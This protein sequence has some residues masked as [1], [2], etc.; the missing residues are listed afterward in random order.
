M[1]KKLIS[2]VAGAALVL[3][4]GA[5]VR[6]FFFPPSPPFITDQWPFCV[7]NLRQIQSAKEQWALESKQ[8]AN[9]LPTW[10]DIR[11]YLTTKATSGAALTC[12]DGGT[13]T[14]GGFGELPR[15]SLGPFVGRRSHTLDGH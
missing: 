14:I 5:T 8:P 1:P 2:A 12:P 7:S 11:P 13:Y 15:C 9:V 3:I 10:D 4:V 6:H